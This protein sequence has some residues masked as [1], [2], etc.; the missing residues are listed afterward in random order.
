MASISL[1]FIQEDGTLE[2]INSKIEEK[3]TEILPT[4]EKRL[5]LALFNCIEKYNNS[6]SNT[7]DIYEIK[8]KRDTT[9][10]AIEITFD[11]KET[12]KTYKKENNY[13]YKELENV[14]TVGY[15]IGGLNLIGIDY[16]RRIT[17]VLG[18]H[19]G[20][21][22]LGY[23]FGAKIHTK[24]QQN[25]LFLNVSWKDAYLGQINGLGLEAGSRWIWSKKRNFGLLYQGGII[26]YNHIDD[27]IVKDLYKGNRPAVSLML[28]IGLSW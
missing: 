11:N 23:T 13:Q 15:Q 1:T 5:R 14:T 25:S 7:S 21:G 20:I 9:E 27:K 28:G 17:K 8:S 24:A 2:K 18:V 10:D 26:I 22:L 12:P 3:T 16:E 4:H 6:L 19:A